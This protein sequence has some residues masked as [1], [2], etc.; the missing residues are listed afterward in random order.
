MTEQKGKVYY[1]E[2][3]KQEVTLNIVITEKNEKQFVRLQLSIPG[4]QGAFSDKVTPDIYDFTDN[5]VV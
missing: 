5:P 4:T 3:L 2:Q 1:L